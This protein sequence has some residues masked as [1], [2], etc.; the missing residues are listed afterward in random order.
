MMTAKLPVVVLRA[1]DTAA[2]EHAVDRTAL[3]T[4]IICYH[5]ARPDLMRHLPQQLLFETTRPTTQLS[6]EDRRTGPHV[7]VRPPRV[8]ADVIELD[9][10][11]RGLDRSTFLADIVCRHM[12][13]PELMRETNVQKEG[14][15]LAM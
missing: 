2:S 12:G 13:Y 15:P 9:Y 7:K 6:D 10:E 4:D 5:Y 1:V 8:V 3:L 14:L 11:N